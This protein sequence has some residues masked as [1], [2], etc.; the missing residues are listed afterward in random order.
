MWVKYKEI[1]EEQSNSGMCSKD[2]VRKVLV[3]FLSEERW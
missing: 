2:N 3:G 1:D